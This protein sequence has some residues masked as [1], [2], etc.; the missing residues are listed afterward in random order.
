MVPVLSEAITVAD[1]NVSMQSSFFM[2]T[3]LAL[4][5]LAMTVRIVVTVV[6]KPSGTFPKI[7]I[8]KPL[9][10][11][12]KIFYP[13]AT[14]IMKKII[15]MDTANPVINLTT[16][17]ISDL[18]LEVSSVVSDTLAAMLPIKV[19]FPVLTTIPIAYPSCTR[20]LLKTRFFDSW[21]CS[22]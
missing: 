2:Y 19:L 22:F 4:N 16:K 13:L 20:Q 18:S 14:P 8:I 3:C 12:V 11:T 15:P 6:G 5:L 7:T 9:M 17:A 21:K 10:K 1:P